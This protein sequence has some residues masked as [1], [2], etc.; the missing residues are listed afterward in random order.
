MGFDP[1]DAREPLLQELAGL[2]AAAGRSAVEE[3]ASGCAGPEPEAT[4]REIL[5]FSQSGGVPGIPSIPAIPK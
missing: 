2:E 1:D 3:I 5:R 4:L